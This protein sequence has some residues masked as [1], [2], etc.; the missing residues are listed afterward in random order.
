MSED[1]WMILAIIKPFKLDAVTLALESMPG[2]A[3]ITV[4]DCRGF[5]RERLADLEEAAADTTGQRRRSTTE[6]LSDF[7]DKVR[8][9]IVVRGRNSGDAVM[10]VIAR[11]AHTG[12]RGD[13]KIFMWPITAAIRIRTSERDSKAL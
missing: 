4:S 6:E 1:M 3:G 7:T 8:V 11:T 13:G 5:G 10:D 9:E 12:R 2:F